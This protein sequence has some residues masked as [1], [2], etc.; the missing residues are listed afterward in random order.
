MACEWPLPPELFSERVDIDMWRSALEATPGVMFLRPVVDAAGVSRKSKV[1]EAVVAR[2][3][4]HMCPFEM[5]VF[6][7][8][9]KKLRLTT[10]LTRNRDF[11]HTYFR[12]APQRVSREKARGIFNAACLIFRN[13]AANEAIRRSLSAPSSPP[14]TAHLTTVLFD[15]EGN[16]WGGEYLSMGVG[17][18]LSA[19]EPPDAVD[20]QGWAY[21]RVLATG[22]AGWY[23][24]TFA[25]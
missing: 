13:M 16:K 19:C 9:S 21:G 12:D 4:G 15:F 17:D 6:L 3:G 7:G 1:A 20:P 11:V 2:G 5:Y 10:G 25:Q 18:L 22:R 14:A 23:P 24:P 8:E